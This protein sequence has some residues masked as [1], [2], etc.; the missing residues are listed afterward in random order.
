[1]FSKSPRVWC[2]IQSP[3]Q[4]WWRTQR[5]SRWRSGWQR[6]PWWWGWW[7]WW[8]ASCQVEICCFCSCSCS[9]ERAHCFGRCCKLVLDYPLSNTRFRARSLFTAWLSPYLVFSSTI[10][11]SDTGYAVKETSCIGW[12]VPGQSLSSFWFMG[13]GVLKAKYVPF[14]FFLQFLH[15]TLLI[16]LMIL[17]KTKLR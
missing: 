13:Q 9:A 5:R 3:Q 15:P 4:Q 2:F 8:G 1:M 10:N 14:I 17:P 7:G 12:M 16:A 6:C 11:M